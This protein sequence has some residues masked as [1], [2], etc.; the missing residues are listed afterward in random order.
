[1]RKY[2]LLLIIL[3]TILGVGCSSLRVSHDYDAAVDFSKMKTYAWQH[4]TQPKTGNAR[5]DNDLENQRIRTFIEQA[6][7]AK[8][9][10]KADRGVADILIGYQLGLQQKVKSDSVQT[11]FGFGFGGR[12]RYGSIGISQGTEVRTYDEGMLLIDVLDPENGAL[13]WRGTGTDTV[14][15]HADRDKKTKALDEA[16]TKILAPFPPQVR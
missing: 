3:S 13:L 7:Q 14:S 11:G 8:G 4:D 5:L 12:G 15:P 2:Y 16:V 6:L 1:M 9:F 10:T